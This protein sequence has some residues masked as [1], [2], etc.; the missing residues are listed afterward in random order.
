M[1]LT[2]GPKM[3][4]SSVTQPHPRRL[5]NT[6]VRSLRPTKPSYLPVDNATRHLLALSAPAILVILATHAYLVGNGGF[7]RHIHGL[8]NFEVA[9]C[10]AAGCALRGPDDLPVGFTSAICRWNGSDPNVYPVDEWLPEGLV[11]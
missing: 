3:I 6:G 11:H 5:T 10:D 7:A 9:V 4:Q 8:L 2:L 1:G